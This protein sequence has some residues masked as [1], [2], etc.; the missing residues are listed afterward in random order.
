MNIAENLK[1][2]NENIA[3]AA[4]KSGRQAADI[5]LIAVT[6]S[7][8]SQILQKELDTLLAGGVSNLGENR[9]QELTVKQPLCDNNI[10]WHMIGSLQRNKVRNVVGRVALIHSL[11]SLRLAEEI[12]RIAVRENVAAD[13]LIEINIAGE[14]TKHGIP[15]E[16]AADFAAEAARLPNIAIKGLMTIAPFVDDGEENRRHFRQMAR[17]FAQLKSAGHNMCHLSMGMTI[18]YETAIEEGAT[19]VRIGTAIF[20]ERPN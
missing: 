18:D 17:L 14:D 12:S 3:R 10:T 2:I 1:I 11:D 6:K 7:V 15:P 13:V 5:T 19:M 8:S 16:A 4:Q 9:V 20:G